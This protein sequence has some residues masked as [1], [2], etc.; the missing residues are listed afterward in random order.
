MN[1]VL[2]ARD[3]SNGHVMWQRKLDNV[4][5]GNG[6]SMQDKLYF[7]AQDGN[8]YAFRGR[9]G[10]PLWHTSIGH[11]PV[12]FISVTLL[13][14][15]NLIIASITNTRNDNGDMYALN[16]QTGMV[17]W[18]TS[19]LCAVASSNDCAAGGRLTYLANGI[20]YG[21]ADDGLSAWDAMNGHFLWRNPRY[22]L[23]GQPQSMVVSHGKVYITNF[24]PRVDV[25]N[26]SSGNFLHSLR[27]SEPNNSGAVVYDITAN[28]DTVY[29][30]GGQ[31]V[32]AYQAS[33]DSLL[34]KQQFNY[35]SG[36]HIYADRNSIYVNYYD[37]AM[38][39]GGIGSSGNNLYALRPSDGQQIW[40]GQA[41]SGANVEEAEFNGLICFSGLNS[42]YGIRASD[43]KRLWQLPVDGYVDGLFAG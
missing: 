43:G 10:Q 6:L 30:L 15:Q 34:W 24:Y 41:P 26:S 14:Y 19:L 23:N 21:L 42:V 38:G 16:A 40:H 37:I 1:K 12:G 28:Q 32:S 17:V 27:P 8:V 7:P 9:D 22:Q 35:H 4:L 31:T 3:P 25:L 33:D 36:G 18:H 2:S 13:A 20:I 5:D 11:G 39:M 29:I